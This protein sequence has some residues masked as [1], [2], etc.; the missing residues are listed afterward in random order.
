MSPA[1]FF[2]LKIALAI[3]SHLWF[4]TNFRIVKNVIMI[5]DRELYQIYRS[6]W[7]VQPF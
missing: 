6:L 7:V 2:F 1:L 3:W 4:R 5:F